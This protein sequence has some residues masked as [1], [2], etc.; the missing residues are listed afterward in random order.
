MDADGRSRVGT[1]APHHG[2]AVGVAEVERDHA[3]PS[4]S[5]RGPEGVLVVVAG[6]PPGVAHRLVEVGAQVAVEV[7]ET[8]ELA[9]LRDSTRPSPDCAR[10]GAQLDAERL[11]QPARERRE[12]RRDW[13]QLAGSVDDDESPRRVATIGRPSGRSESP[14]TRAPPLRHRDRRD[15]PA[16][17]LAFRGSPRAGCQS[18][19]VSAARERRFGAIWN[20]QP[21]A[22]CAT[23]T[24]TWCSP[25]DRWSSS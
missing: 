6:D 13:R 15:P 8:R 7:D 3:L 22:S 5:K 21:P 19:A 20:D 25:G 2:R 9:A 10:I 12:L 14:P 24:K 23:F 17:R 11:L 1:G 18:S 4:A 16:L